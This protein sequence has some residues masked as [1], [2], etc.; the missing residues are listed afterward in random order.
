MPNEFR[1]FICIIF[2][3]KKENVVFVIIFYYTMC[4]IGLWFASLS[5]FVAISLQFICASCEKYLKWLESNGIVKLLWRHAHGTSARAKLAGILHRITM[6]MQ[7]ANEWVTFINFRVYSVVFSRSFALLFLFAFGKFYYFL[8]FSTK[9]NRNQTHLRCTLHI[10]FDF[11]F[12]LN[13]FNGGE[14]IKDWRI[15]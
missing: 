7:N 5:A 4:I 14:Y 12:I 13:S 3:M 2:F 15:W 11:I 10:Q 9:I 8:I 1:L 6:D